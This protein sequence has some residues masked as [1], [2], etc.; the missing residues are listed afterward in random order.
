MT[1][2]N[3]KAV[4]P[5]EGNL[6]KPAYRKPEGLLPRQ[7]VNTKLSHVVQSVTMG[8]T[9]A[10][11]GLTGLLLMAPNVIAMGSAGFGVLATGFITYEILSSHKKAK[12]D[13]EYNK[14]LD[15]Y[16][17]DFQGHIRKVY[18]INLTDQQAETLLTL[19]CTAY[20]DKQNLTKLSMRYDTTGEGVLTRKVV[21]LPQKKQMTATRAQKA[22]A[23]TPTTILPRTLFN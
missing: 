4:K 19:N 12:S 3:Y 9:T 22:M 6:G 5:V 18:G 15:T 10:A 17:S 7:V 2:M 14:Q 8:S 23:K 21:P 1:D 11:T 16:V 13:I 20:S